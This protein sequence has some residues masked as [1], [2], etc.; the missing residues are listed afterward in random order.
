MRSAKEAN[1]VNKGP[2]S[3]SRGDFSEAMALK[4]KIRSFDRKGGMVFWAE[5]Y[6]WDSKGPESGNSERSARDRVMQLS[7]QGG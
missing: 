6:R 2:E 7:K 3:G 5:T 4:A 1:Q